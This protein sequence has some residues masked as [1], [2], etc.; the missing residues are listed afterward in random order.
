MECVIKGARFI[1]F[2]FIKERKRAHQHYLPPHEL[3]L[4]SL[5]PVLIKGTRLGYIASTP[6]LTYWPH[7][8]TGKRMHA[9]QGHAFR[10]MFCAAGAVTACMRAGAYL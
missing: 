4:I 6:H 3:Y 7:F 2:G 8:L 9:A 5:I 10:K 1:H